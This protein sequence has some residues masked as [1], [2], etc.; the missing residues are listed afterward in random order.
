VKDLIHAAL[1]AYLTQGH[2]RHLTFHSAINALVPSTLTGTLSYIKN[3]F[4]DQD[5]AAIAPSSSFLVRR[6]CK[7]IDF[8][9]DQVIVEYG[10][11][12]GVF[13]EFI[14]DRMTA[15]S[16]LLLIESNP[17]FVET[18][19]EMTAEDPRTIV[20]EDRAEHV[21]DIL[22]VH[23]L[24]EVDYIISGIPFSFLD[25]TTTHDLLTKTREVL[26]EKGKFLVYQNYNHLEEPLREHFSEVTKEYE[27]RNIPPTMFAYEA[28]K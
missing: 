23:G 20:V 13:S 1:S 17:D 4:K 3:F 11:G 2:Y 25:A 22:E 7:W 18:L 5:V 14:L 6:V 24:E 26:S 28:K 27:P 8:D 19:E 21:V 10:P 9:E 15:D 16:T 12:N